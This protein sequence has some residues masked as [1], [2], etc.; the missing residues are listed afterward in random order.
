M[1]PDR[2]PRTPSTP[3]NVARGAVRSANLERRFVEGG[4][5]EAGEWHYVGEDGEPPFEGD[6]ANIGGGRVPTRFRT[7]GDET[8]IELAC[9]GTPASD[10]FV[11]PLD[12]RPSYVMEGTVSDGTPNGV[13]NITVSPNG[14]VYAE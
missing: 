9:N 10:I 6:W 11:L 1:I 13:Q 7:F 12:W 5:F 3:R 4:T 2:A 14:H 8:E